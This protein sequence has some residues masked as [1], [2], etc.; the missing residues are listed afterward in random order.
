MLADSLV[1]A[2]ESL[3]VASV[4]FG[5]VP[6]SK[7]EQLERYREVRDRPEAWTNMIRERGHREALRYAKSMERQYRRTTEVG[8]AYPSFGT[9]GAMDQQRH[10]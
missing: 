1:D 8:N 10:R 4:P 5:Q 9:P 7:D 6:L 3:P 2:V